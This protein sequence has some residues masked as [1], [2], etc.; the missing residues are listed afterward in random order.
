MEEFLDKSLSHQYF[1]R[2]LQELFIDENWSPVDSEA[3]HLPYRILIGILETLEVK[4]RP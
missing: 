3:G 4:C 1:L 2:N